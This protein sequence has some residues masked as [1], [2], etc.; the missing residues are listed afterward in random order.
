MTQDLQHKVS[1]MDVKGMHWCYDK[2]QLLGAKRLSLDD[3]SH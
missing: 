1:E 2:G 3:V